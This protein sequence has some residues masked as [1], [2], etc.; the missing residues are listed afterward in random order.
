MKFPTLA[1]AFAMLGAAA[2]DHFKRTGQRTAF[3][4]RPG[5][6][7]N[8]SDRRA[9]QAQRMIASLTFE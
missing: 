3:W 2:H 4:F 5:V 1:A 9:R 8:S 7:V 6:A